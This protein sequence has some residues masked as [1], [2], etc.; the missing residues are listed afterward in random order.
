MQYAVPAVA[1]TEAGREL[2]RLGEV[3]AEMIELSCHALLQE[4]ADSA[5]RVFVLEDEVVDPVT[6]ELENFV[7]NLMRSELS[8]A[9]Q[10]RAFQIKNLLIDIERVG[11]MAEDIA[12]HAIDRIDGAIP[13]SDAA[14]RELTQLSRMAHTIYSQSL[15]A[16]REDDAALALQVCREE[17]E[18]DCL[19]WQIRETHIQRTEVGLCHPKASVIFTETLRLLERISD[20]ADNL[21]VSVSRS[22]RH[23]QPVPAAPAQAVAVHKN[24]TQKTPL[25]GADADQ[26]DCILTP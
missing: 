22:L 5:A 15:Q 24:G 12:H 8:L 2:M 17:N 26:K 10:K 1:I 21:G 4:D 19:Y 11:D 13:F 7:N 6:N 14:I 18:F 23:V 9:Q 20:H 25:A 16:F 3:T